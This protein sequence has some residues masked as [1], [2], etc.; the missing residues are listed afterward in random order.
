MNK[1]N[2]QKL[3]DFLKDLPDEEFDMGTWLVKRVHN[4]KTKGCL[5][6]WAYT[7]KLEEE[8]RTVEWEFIP[9]DDD[10]EPGWDWADTAEGDHV[11]QQEAASWLGL[12]TTWTGG[13][14]ES[15]QA[16]RLFV[17]SGYDIGRGTLGTVTKEEAIAVL[18]HMI[19]HGVIEW[20]ASLREITEATADARPTE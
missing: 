10:G 16:N 13:E 2:I 11:V 1:V 20:N 19:S 14:D 15:P 18:E 4:C 6:G 5:A 9:T 3:I 12:T 8:G 7:L 17:P